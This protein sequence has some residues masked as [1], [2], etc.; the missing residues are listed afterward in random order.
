MLVVPFSR[1]MQH[2]T[3][4]MQ[5]RCDV[6]SS[7]DLNGSSLILIGHLGAN[8]INCSATL[9]SKVGPPHPPHMG[10]CLVSP[11]SLIHNG[12]R[13]NALSDLH[14]VKFGGQVALLSSLSCW[15][16]ASVMGVC[17]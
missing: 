3:K 8:P 2:P 11:F 4:T 16:G 15:R 5:E 1:T 14:L 17:W 12:A 13:I 10:L 9:H 7:E 6:S